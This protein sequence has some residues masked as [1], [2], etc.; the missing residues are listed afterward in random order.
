MTIDAKG[1]P[2]ETTI[3]HTNLI[4]KQMA[5]SLRTKSWIIIAQVSCREYY[6]YYLV[7]VDKA[8]DNVLEIKEICSE[9]FVRSDHLIG[10]SE[11]HLAALITEL[12]LVVELERLEIT[13]R[14][15]AIRRDFE[16]FKSE[17]F[18]DYTIDRLL[19]RQNLEEWWKKLM[20]EFILQETD[21]KQID[22]ILYHKV[23]SI[24]EEV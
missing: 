15:M 6:T 14:L 2:V 17:V 20:K 21:F 13:D 23:Q 12:D 19:D 16:Q 24:P 5:D 10:N 22:L 11:A 9:D 3:P 7:T 4:S 18:E 8:I 1:R